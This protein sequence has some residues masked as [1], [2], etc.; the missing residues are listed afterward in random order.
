MLVYHVVVVG[1]VVVVVVA[2]DRGYVA[3]RGCV[4]HHGNRGIVTHFDS[5]H[6]GVD[7][8]QMLIHDMIHWM[9]DR[10]G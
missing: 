10:N 2:D 7:E 8:Y 1:Q 6:R 5:R 3:R 9:N 4:D